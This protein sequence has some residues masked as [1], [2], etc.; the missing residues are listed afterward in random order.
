MK[1]SEKKKKIIVQFLHDIT[2]CEDCIHNSD[3]E[4]Y[5]TKGTICSK[6]LDFYFD[7]GPVKDL[8]FEVAPDDTNTLY[9]A[10]ASLRNLALMYDYRDAY[11]A[12]IIKDFGQRA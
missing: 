9:K 10:I 7:G 11:D 8:A 1:Y 3:A 2:D 4:F 6:C 5:A 12:E